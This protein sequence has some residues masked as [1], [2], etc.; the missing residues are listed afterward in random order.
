MNPTWMIALG[1]VIY[2]LYA[3]L[4]FKPELKVS[5]YLMPIG[6]SLALI[7]NL[8][9]ILL[10]KSTQE[11]AKLIMYGMMWDTM[12]TLSFLLVPMMFFGVRF[13]LVGGVGCA[14]VVVGL[15]MMKLGTI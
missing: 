4:T 11:P 2:S 6:L 5:A 8:L 9:W 3:W 12:I 15:L 10:A 13:T 7:G 14:L 1:T